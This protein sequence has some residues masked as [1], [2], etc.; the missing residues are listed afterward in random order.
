MAAPQRLTRDATLEDLESV[1]SHLNG[2]IL[3]GELV[4]SPRPAPRHGLASSGLGALVGGPFGF[5]MGGPGGWWIIAEPELHLGTDL[6]TLAV[7]PDLA[8]W[9][10]E[11][12]PH[13]PETAYF[14]Q[15]PDWICEVL[16][17]GNMGRDRSLKMPFYAHAGVGHAWL[18]DPIAETLEVYRRANELQWLLLATYHGPVTVRAEPF[19]AIEI[20]LTPLWSR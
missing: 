12:M 8:G 14:A 11:K 5:G 16:S 6:R 18:V 1:P 13:L 17:P 20:D 2:E 10:R 3:D 19:D 7:I 9:R 4:L 15:V